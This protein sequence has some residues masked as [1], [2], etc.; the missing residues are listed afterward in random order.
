M[1]SS[2]SLFV[3]GFLLGALITCIGFALMGQRGANAKPYG[4]VLTVAHGLPAGHPVHEA[5]QEFG[6]ELVK[7]SDAKMSV[8]I[9]PSEQ[10]GNETECLEKLQQGSIDI[11]KVGAA[12][13]GNFVPIYKTLSLPYLFR[14]H[15]HFWATLSSSIGEDLLA[16][17]SRTETGSPSG[18][19][20]LAFYD[21]GSRSFYATRKLNGLSDLKGLKI[22][23]QQDPV[24]ETTIRALGA[25]AVAMG[26]GELYTSLQQGGVDGAENNPPSFFSSRHFEVCKY[27]MLDEHSSI[28]DVLL[29]SSALWESLGDD[30]RAWLRAAAS[31][32]SK[33]QR[34]L[35]A[36]ETQRALRELKRAGVSVVSVDKR[37]FR[38]A[39]QSVVNEFATKDS[40]ELVEQM[41]AIR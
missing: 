25:S 37:P 10:L 22:R 35:W 3:G 40:E 21:A 15:E 4:R 1:K 38:M 36:Q 12:P 17:V 14:D 28:P 2:S 34:Q 7:L 31:H 8:R 5:L 19:V 9:Y 32:S 11:T 29:A 26:F 13:I 41:K 23:V 6:R 39:V 20:G 24:A 16:A 27:Y 30:E 18:L 33:Y